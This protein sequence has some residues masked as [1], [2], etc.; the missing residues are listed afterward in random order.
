MKLEEVENELTKVKTQFK[1]YKE[2]VENTLEKEY[3]T[4]ILTDAMLHSIKKFNSET[5]VTLVSSEAS[6]KKYEEDLHDLHK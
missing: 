4:K 1:E 5:Y 6:H 3:Y 2:S